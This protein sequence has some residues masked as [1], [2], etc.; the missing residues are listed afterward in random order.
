MCVCVFSP[1]SSSSVCLVYAVPSP[2]S[3]ILLSTQFTAS[4][5]SY[6]LLTS[7]LFPASRAI[8]SYIN[9]Y[10]AWCVSPPLPPPPSPCMFI[11]VMVLMLFVLVLLLFLF[12]PLF[13]FLLSFSYSS[14]SSLISSSSFSSLLFS[15]KPPPPPPPLQQT[16][17][18][19]IQPR[20]HL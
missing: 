2:S 8:F 20:K 3:L 10:K 15:L 18:L 16:A 6:N 4:T 17:F 13:A 12:S 1:S 14:V 9:I 11:V 19:A 5:L 7:L